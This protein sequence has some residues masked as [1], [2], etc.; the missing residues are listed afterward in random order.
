MA[1]PSFFCVR[2]GKCTLP[3]PPVFISV[4]SK[5]FRLHQNC[6]KRGDPQNVFILP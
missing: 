2:S 6:A 1:D 5:G 3:Y 4:D